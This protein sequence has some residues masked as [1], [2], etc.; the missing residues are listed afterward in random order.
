M[1]ILAGIF[2][3]RFTPGRQKAEGKK[4]EAGIGRWRA[5]FSLLPLAVCLLILI[6]PGCGKIG[7]PLPPAPR[8]PLILDELNVAQEGTQIILQ[9]PIIRSPRSPRLQRIDIYRSIESASDPLG[10]TQEQYSANATIIDSILGEEVPLEKSVITK[11]DTLDPKNGTSDQRYR[12][13]VRMVTSSG[14]AA[15]FSNYALITPLFDISS[16]PS[17]LKSEQKER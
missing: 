13:A 1:R 3:K 10:V 2:Y 4:M 16:P 9:F 14:V 7:D 15:N 5:S 6:L 8:S 12:Y 11:I 17:G